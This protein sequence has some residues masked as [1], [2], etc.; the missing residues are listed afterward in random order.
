MS[1]KTI[2][3]WSNEP[4]ILLNKNYIG[5]L[6]PTPKM[7]YEQ[8]L[9]AVSRLVILLSIL[10]FIFTM[11]VKMLIVGV[12]TLVV[13]FVLYKT[14]PQKITKDTLKESFVN[15]ASNVEDDVDQSR[16]KII[17][18]ETLE[19][20]L[21]SQFEENTKTNPMANVLLTD[22]GD[23]PNRKSAPPAFNVDVYED[24]TKSTKKMVQKLNPGIKN[25]NKQLFGD[26]GE[27]WN[28]DQSMRRF[29]S[30]ANT[31]VANDQGAFAQFLYGNMPSAKEG[32]PFALVQDNPR[33]NLY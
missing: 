14:Q 6:W 18:P 15:S 4:T 17:N 7:T 11:S 28:L 29:Y 13:L 21:K 24:I 8:K 12:I 2:P 20:F 10:G 22:I 33:Y 5:E 9:N 30:T 19:T 32:D 23:N 27:K 3:F 16:Q 31:K 1:S 25:T 26:L